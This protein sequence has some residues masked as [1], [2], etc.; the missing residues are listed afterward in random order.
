VIAQSEVPE[1]I[2][3]ST[4]NSSP[5]DRLSKFVADENNYL[6]NWSLL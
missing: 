1:A 2:K 4:I 6:N 3:P 5:L